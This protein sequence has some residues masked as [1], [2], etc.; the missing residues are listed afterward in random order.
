MI[1]LHSEDNKFLFFWRHVMTSLIVFFWAKTTSLLLWRQVTTSL[2][3]SQFEKYAFFHYILVFIP[4][5]FATV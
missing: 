1:F 4:N 3:G 2:I 5:Y